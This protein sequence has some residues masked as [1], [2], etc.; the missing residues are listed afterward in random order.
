MIFDFDFELFFLLFAFFFHYTKY[1]SFSFQLV[2]FNLSHN[3]LTKKALSFLIVNLIKTHIPC[4][5][6][7]QTTGKKL[8]ILD[9]G[10]FL[11]EWSL[12]GDLKTLKCM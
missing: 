2:S 6:G 1:I 3:R 7:E 4:V 11:V 9:I 8:Y 5:I 12:D 10:E